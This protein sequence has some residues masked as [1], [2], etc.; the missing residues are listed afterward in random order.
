MKQNYFSK[1]KINFLISLSAIFFSLASLQANAQC[2]LDSNDS[3]AITD[4]N[5]T[6]TSVAFS[7]MIGN[8]FKACATG[9]L[10]SIGIFSL[11]NSTGINI[12]VYDGE[13]TVG[14]VLG[15]VNGV[16]VSAATSIDDRS[17]I[18]FSS[19]GIT[20]ISGNTYTWSV[21]SG[22]IDSRVTNNSI[23]ADGISYYDGYGYSE[24]E[25]LF[26]I[27]ISGPP[28]S[29]PTATAPTAPIVIENDTN[30]ALADN[31]QVTDADGD[32]QTVNFTV[33]GGTV[34]LGTTGITFGGSGNGSANFT[35]TGSLA[36]INV[37]LDAATFTPTPNLNGTNA[38]TIS[39][40]TYDGADTS[41]PAAVT[42]D[43]SV[44]IVL[45]ITGLT[46]DHK[47][48]NATTAA[49]ASGTASLSG[50]VGTDDVSLGGSPVFTFANVN[51]G[52]GITI[53][54]TGYTIS[55]TDA[56]KYTLT[57]PTLSADITVQPLTITGL[58]GNDK[59][60]DGTTTATVSGTASLSAIV[61]ADDVSL[62]GSPVFTFASANVG[63]EITIT[64]TGYTISGTDSGNYSVTQP[65]L[66]ADITAQPLTITGLTGDDKVYDE[67]TA[68][69]A[70]G[71]AILSGIVGA[72]VVSLGG[73]PV[74]TFASADVGTEIT[75]TTTGYT[76]SGTDSGNYSVT[77]PTLSAD[78]T[79]VTLA[80][81]DFNIGIVNIYPNPTSEALYIQI[82]SDL[83]NQSY[84]IY[85]LLGK[86]V[87]EGILSNDK[88]VI[89]V[90]DL[91]KG[92]YL[93]RIGENKINKFIKK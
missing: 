76:I 93:L 51:V 21:V 5:F 37:A 63:T 49:T 39:F 32:N 12:L 57:Q 58:T 88:T 19:T 33:T 22:N 30:V 8:S 1:T 35:A 90:N 42:F 14:T 36:G 73:S 23:Y 85:D 66:S 92:I 71:T 15:S 7:G 83:L 41:S 45:T 55:G 6:S 3:G 48:Y 13:G 52:T 27:D 2:S 87:L 16:S 26:Y 44:P 53:T 4:A 56:G 34:N 38:A 68:A 54:T 40:T 62:E 61:G 10:N 86:T 70:S 80:V 59:V 78:I 18:D 64:T 84:K 91:S 60:Y 17:I 46:G 29:I 79:A 72:D 20:L 43:I 25:W 9:S 81:D 75:I 74:F 11:S 65:T 67:T 31:I 28:N 24:N 50:I 77:Q 89:N 69:T 82:T 47:T